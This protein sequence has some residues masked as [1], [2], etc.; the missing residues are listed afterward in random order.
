MTLI[1][2]ALFVFTL[3]VTTSVSA[4]VSSSAIAQTPSE[5]VFRQA[6]SSPQMYAMGRCGD[7]V[8]RL[9]QAMIQNNIPAIHSAYVIFIVG[10]N[11]RVPPVPALRLVPLTP[12]NAR[13]NAEMWDFHVILAMTHESG[14]VA[15]YDMDGVP[16]PMNPEAYFARMF[17]SSNN[18]SVF[19]TGDRTKNLVIRLIPIATYLQEFQ[20]LG[21]DRL[22][23]KYRGDNVPGIPKGSARD[24]LNSLR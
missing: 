9:A 22:A 13:N 24:F 1:S 16:Q 14:R 15:I 23:S 3:A 6:Y 4:Q 18:G 8:A 17:P 19:D 11:R 12:T 5:K 20:A 10:E 21:G 2:R 7:N